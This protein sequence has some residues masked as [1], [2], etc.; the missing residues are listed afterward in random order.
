M[1]AARWTHRPRYVVVLLL[2][3]VFGAIP[4]EGGDFY[5][6]ATAAG[7]R[8]NVLYKK[9]VDSTDPRNFSLNQG[10]IFRTDDSATELAYRVGLLAGYK[11]PLS[12]TGV[13]VALE[14]DMSRH[15]GVT[16]GRLAGAGTSAGR[17]QLGEVWPENW[18]LGNDKSYG[19]T[20]RLGAGIPFFGT[21]FG[22]SAYA[23]VGVRR[24]QGSFRSEYTGCL[25][26]E[27]CEDPAEFTS[28]SDSFGE[29]FNG[30]TVGGGVEKKLGSFAVRGEVRRTDYRKSGR[31]VPFDDIFVT[32][33]LE[34]EPD[35]LSFGV[36]LLWYF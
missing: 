15:G 34:L 1:Q 32:V 23:L 7:D 29:N 19:L 30:W 17:N 21:W 5:V 2:V 18:T 27:P 33:P 36:S 12:L 24:L 4:A 14:G 35:S 22:P 3:C 16:A 8:L 25:T 10:E 28:G 20:A 9:V 31:V 11:V 26:A 6:G 13:Y